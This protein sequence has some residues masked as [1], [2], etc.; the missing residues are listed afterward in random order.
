MNSDHPHNSGDTLLVPPA[1]TGY[2]ALKKYR[3]HA[4][5]RVFVN[6][7][8]MLEKIKYFGFDMDYTL[9]VYKSPQYE[10]MGFN[11]TVERL[12]A[13]GY[14]QELYNN[15]YD[16]SFPVRGMLF[17]KHLG[18]LIK[19]DTFGNILVCVHGFRFLNSKEIAELYPNKFITL[20]SD[21]L[22]VLNTLFNLPET[23]LLACC[24]NYFSTS[25]EYTAVSSSV[26]VKKGDLMLSWESIFEDVRN[27]VDWV[28]MKGALK[29]TTV[30]QP[31]EYVIKDPRLPV[32][33]QRMR[34]HGRKV[35]L[36]TNSDYNYTKK[37]MTYLFD[38]PNGPAPDMPHKPWYQYFDVCIVSANK[39]KFFGT[40]SVLRQVDLET[41]ALKIGTHVGPFQRGQVYS[42]GSCDT[43]CELMGCRGN[44][45]LY[46]GDHIFGDILKS[47]KERGWRTFLVVP[48]VAQDLLVWTEK[49]SLFEKLEDLDAALADKYKYLDSSTDV[50]P[51]ISKVRKAIQQVTHEMDMCHGK[52]G[53]LFRSGS[54]QTF[55]A[56][57]VL[58]YADLYSSTFLNLLHY[59]FSYLFRAPHQLMPHEF[60]V[61][62]Q[63][64]FQ[65]EDTMADTMM[66]PA[67]RRK[68]PGNSSN[69][70][71]VFESPSEA[72]KKSL[73][74]T[75]PSSVQVQPSAPLEITHVHD[76]DD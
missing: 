44:D 72:Q 7:S 73:H 45:V 12:V 50:I 33:L 14:P 61:D 66:S 76:D 39:P 52:L 54:R 26:G 24:V 47:K 48:E 69:S 71:D 59:P 4:H 55:F 19:V 58:R 34:D 28:H 31:D 22:Y 27:A 30:D 2:K 6:R 64:T 1:A 10:T 9:A 49:Q 37:I 25:S 21:R 65:E 62:H 60:T 40:G 16:P 8:L 67:L 42:G 32:L 43:F 41:G 15:E 75:L 46:I 35:F 11:L 63:D 13:I 74:M 56:S 29:Q 17:D 38:F 36:V 70:A 3:R 53:S 20:K 23:Y 57:Q 51:D 18:N 5:K 68:R